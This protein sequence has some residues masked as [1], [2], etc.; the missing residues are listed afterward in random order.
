LLNTFKHIFVQ[1]S[2][3][4]DLLHVNGIENVSV[5]GDTRFDRVYDLFLQSKQLPIIEAFVKGSSKIIVAGSTWAKDEELL[6][7]YL[8]HHSDIK[9]IL[10]P[11]EIHESHISEISRLLD[12]NFI[13][14]SNASP[15]NVISANCLVVDVIG[16]LSSIYRYADVAY[17]GGGFGVGIHNTLEAAVFGV[18]VLFG[19]TYYKFREARE[20]ISAGGA[21]SI[22][23]Y[24]I[25]E[26]LINSL[27]IDAS[28][29]KI[30]GDYVKQNRGATNIIIEY[31]KN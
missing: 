16:I 28:A 3:S 29:G 23:N 14:Y 25:F 6:V 2:V 20:L 27:F 7:Q 17:I 31:L 4:K 1:D 11:H 24:N 9:L 10:V 18:P 30:A 22:A 5:A 8:K 15:E 26:T 12:G 21:F 13:R 19:P